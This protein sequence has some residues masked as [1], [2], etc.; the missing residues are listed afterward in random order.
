MHLIVRI[1]F[2]HSPNT[3][4]RNDQD[5]AVVVSFDLDFTD[6]RAMDFGEFEAFHRA[7]FL[8]AASALAAAAA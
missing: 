6:W 3:N 8:W 2:M 1:V 4:C 7:Y 5:R